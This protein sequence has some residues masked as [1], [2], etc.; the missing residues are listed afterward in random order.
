MFA[1]EVNYS[2]HKHQVLNY[3]GWEKKK[4]QTWNFIHVFIIQNCPKLI[5]SAYCV[6][7]FGFSVPPQHFNRFIWMANKPYN[8]TGMVLYQF[9]IFNDFLMIVLTWMNTYDLFSHVFYS[10]F[11]TFN[12]SK[13]TWLFCRIRAYKGALFIVLIIIFSPPFFTKIL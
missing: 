12:R 8:T 2:S 10:I 1:T 5:A 9:K 4:K 3:L 11:C 6:G 7:Y 13:W